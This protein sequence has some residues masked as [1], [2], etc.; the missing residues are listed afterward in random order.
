[1]QRTPV[2]R[3]FIALACL[4]GSVLTQQVT[5]ADLDKILVFGAPLQYRLASSPGEILD[6]A[7]IA[8][9]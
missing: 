5:G 2:F 4:E 9:A 8:P 1:M 6:C 7:K 3:F